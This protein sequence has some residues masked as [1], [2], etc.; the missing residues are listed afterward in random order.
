ME[1]IKFIKDNQINNYDN[2]K[3]ILESNPFNLKIKEDVDYPHLFL[4]Y[5]EDNSNFDL[6]IVNECNGIILNKQTLDIVCY[7]FDKCNEDI[8]FP[9]NNFN[10]D[11]LY[12]EKSIE[13][14]LVRLFFDKIS[15]GW[16]LSTKKCIDASKS[17]WISNKS[18]DKLFNDCINFHI[19]QLDKNVCYSFI[20]CHPENKIIVFYQKPMLFHIS[21]RDMITLK[22]I[23]EDIGSIQIQR[24]YIHKDSLQ[25]FLNSIKIDTNLYCEG[26]IFIDTFY[27]R[28]KIKTP[29][30]KKVRNIWGNTN[31]RFYR[32]LELRK[33]DELLKEYLY[34]FIHDIELFKVYELKINNLINKIVEC[35]IHKHINKTI[36]KIPF[37]FSKIIYKLQGDYYKDKIKTDFNKVSLKILNTD[38]KLICYMINNLEKDESVMD[39]EN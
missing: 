35:Y 26:Y 23:N 5:S 37:Y 2:L 39:M 12:I 31:N 20:I 36:E 4:I 13:G 6:K 24:E 1:L 33:D 7:T 22:E 29:F 3:N 14:T 8:E 32:Y 17:K 21:S 9:V 18:F 11:N 15:D 10:L 38:I 34:Y 30:F 19:D 25:D 27:N 28:W 16:L